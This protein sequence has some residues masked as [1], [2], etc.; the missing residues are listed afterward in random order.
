MRVRV[1]VSLLIALLAASQAAAQSAANGSRAEP[2]PRFLAEPPTNPVHHHTNRIT[3]DERSLRTGWA[4]L[5]QC[6]T[7][8]DALGASQIVFQEGNVRDLAVASTTNIARTRVRDDRVLLDGVERGAEICLTAKTRAVERHADGSVSVRNGPFM[9]RLFDSY[10][11]MRVTLIIR[12]P[13][14]RLAFQSLTP[15]PRPGLSLRR[16][17]G[18]LTVEAWFE[19]TLRTHIRLRPVTD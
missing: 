8:M 7:N 11:A 9:R 18:R 19:G 2:G 15:E 13:A 16:D 5:R 3:L 1:P 4:E 6:H 12:Y 14:D 17:P 10:F